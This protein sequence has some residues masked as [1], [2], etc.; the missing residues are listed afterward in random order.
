MAAAGTPPWGKVLFQD[1][2]GRV[3]LV[4]S[5]GSWETPGGGMPE[6]LSGDERGCREFVASVAAKLGLRAT[7]VRLAGV[8]RQH[9]EGRPGPGRQLR[10]YAARA[11]VLGAS[12]Y[13]EES[14]WFTADEAV[15]ATPYPM[16]KR[17]LS[18]LT[19]EPGQIW[20]A[21]YEVNYE[22]EPPGGSLRVIQDLSPLR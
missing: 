12:T 8:F 19:A 14:R 4:K 2:R 18:R 6:E 5:K 22:M 7:E 10:W 9:F 20:T 1:K 21:E 11:E 17:I 15:L 13:G 16:G 3:L